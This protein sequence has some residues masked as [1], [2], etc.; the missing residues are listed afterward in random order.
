MILAAIARSPSGA[1][2]NFGVSTAVNLRPYCDPAVAERAMNCQAT[3]GIEADV[4]VADR[5]RSLWGG[6]RKSY[7]E[8]IRAGEYLGGLR[9]FNVGE[10]MPRLP[11]VGMETSNV[12]EVRVAPPIEDAWFA[13][14]WTGQGFPGYAA[15]IAYSV[16]GR[17]R[18][19]VM[20]NG[21][22]MA[23]NEAAWFGRTVWKGIGEIE[24]ESVIGEAIERLREVQ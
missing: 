17:L 23:E 12:G 22:D 9:A 7:G 20:T 5:V 13:V 15:N 24:P 6:L 18:G 8:R 11:G 14:F 21:A 3:M 16:K 4:A 2:A 1:A 10:S 19:T